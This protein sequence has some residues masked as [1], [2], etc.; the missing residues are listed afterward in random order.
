[1]LIVYVIYGRLVANVAGPSGRRP[2]RALTPLASPQLA[3][4]PG[5]TAGTPDDINLLMRLLAAW[6]LGIFGAADAG[7]GFVPPRRVVEEVVEHCV[8]SRWGFTCLT[9][10]NAPPK[11]LDV[12]VA[13]AKADASMMARFAGRSMIGVTAGGSR[14]RPTSACAT[15]AIIR[16]R[17]DAT[18]PQA[19]RT[20]IATAP[21]R[22]R[23]GGGGGGS[24]GGV[25]G[26]RAARQQARPRA[27]SGG[28][29][30]RRSR[31]A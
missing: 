11:I 26:W 31:A 13:K 16:R 21:P 2:E 22:Q 7:R 8:S 20:R 29:G 15:C 27:P 23:R 3:A 6:L 9:P 19:P 24:G 4:R 5:P 30:R 14:T 12:L 1:M 25:L 28:A 10:R 17:L 18:L